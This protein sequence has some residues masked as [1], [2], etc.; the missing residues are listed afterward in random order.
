MG[1]WWIKPDEE[2][3]ETASGSRRGAEILDVALLI[4]GPLILLLY[5]VVEQRFDAWHIFI[6]VCIL[7]VLLLR[8]NAMRKRKGAR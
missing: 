3:T 4:L 6:G 8:L 2:E 5:F 7:L 1:S